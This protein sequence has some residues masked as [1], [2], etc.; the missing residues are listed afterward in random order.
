ML[1]WVTKRLSPRRGPETQGS[2]R[3]QQ[4]GPA[5]GP[6]ELP[7]G[8]FETFV[9]EAGFDFLDFGCSSGG[10][11]AWAKKTLGAKR[12]L[13]IDIDKAKVEAARAAGCDA[14][15]FDIMDIP[16]TKLVDFTLLS[17][18]LEHVPNTLQAAE[19]IKRACQVSR[20]FVLI[21]QPYFDADGA[22]FLK[23]LKLYWSHWRGHRYTMSS[24]NLY[25]VLAGLQQ[26][27]AIE[28][29]SIHHRDPIHSSDDPAI[30]P[31]ESPIDQHAYD[32]AR[33]PP[34]RSVSFDFP[35]FKETVAIAWIERGSGRDLL[36]KL[37]SP[38]L[39]FDSSQKA[40]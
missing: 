11:I 1:N 32:P 38:T 10:S 22:L 23:G 24:L 2:D 29:F 17:H 39:V 20:E 6:I 8:R 40:G 35:V 31:I 28:G 30:H 14:V 13:G 15:L 16:A 21:K 7:Q 4:P 37:K 33:H 3:V 36:K 34:K 9:R 19:F 12:G 5:V 25:C 18:F 27:G 26:S